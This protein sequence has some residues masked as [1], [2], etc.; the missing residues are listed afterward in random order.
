MS[1]AVVARNTG[2]F[3]SSDEAKA[4]LLEG[5]RIE[6]KEVGKAVS[7]GSSIYSKTNFWINES[8]PYV[9]DHKL[10]RYFH[11]P[12]M[13]WIFLFLFIVSLAAPA[14]YI[15]AFVMFG[16]G[17]IFFVIF[18]Q[19]M[20]VNVKTM[21]YVLKQTSVPNDWIKF[22]NTFFVIT[23]EKYRAFFAASSQAGIGLITSGKGTIK[24]QVFRKSSVGKMKNCVVLST[25]AFLGSIF[26]VCY[27]LGSGI[28]RSF[29][30]VE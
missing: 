29:D 20:Y 12:L 5:E 6:V 9:G 28:G 3:V 15:Y 17:L 11:L 4:A 8:R 13:M 30:M 22:S 26:M 21:R 24:I 19:H 7:T 2:V 1:Q 16:V 25:M 18:L 10:T 14:Y 23:L 27:C